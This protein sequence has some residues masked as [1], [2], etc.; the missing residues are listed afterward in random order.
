M[1]VPFPA[2]LWWREAVMVR[3]ALLIRIAGPSMLLD[4]GSDP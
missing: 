4:L 3:A 1:D 2:C